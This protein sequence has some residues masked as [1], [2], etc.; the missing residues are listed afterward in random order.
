M[1]SDS[2]IYAVSKE[3]GLEPEAAMKV[4]VAL[5]MNPKTVER[6]TEADVSLDRIRDVMRAIGEV[7]V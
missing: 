1:K 5:G 3:A 2:L 7:A 6:F 4:L